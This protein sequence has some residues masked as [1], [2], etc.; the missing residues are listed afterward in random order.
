MKE[1]EVK[2]HG[3][4]GGRNPKWMVKVLEIRGGD[5]GTVEHQGDDSQS[6]ISDVDTGDAGPG[7]VSEGVKAVWR[8]MHRDERDENSIWLRGIPASSVSDIPATAA[9]ST[10]KENWGWGG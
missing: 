1:E 4:A 8:T 2:L 3:R 9:I 10:G 6:Y 7:T 5:S